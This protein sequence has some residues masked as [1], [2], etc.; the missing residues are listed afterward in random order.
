[1]RASGG[2][3]N[4]AWGTSGGDHEDHDVIILRRLKCDLPMGRAQV[5]SLRPLPLRDFV[6]AREAPEVA[7]A[8]DNQ[9]RWFPRGSV[10]LLFLESGTQTMRH[11]AE[12][13]VATWSNLNTSGSNVMLAPGTDL[14]VAEGASAEVAVAALLEAS[15]VEWE[16]TAND[17]NGRE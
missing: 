15:R 7:L 9:G 10:H 11:W 16:R 4:P 13:P 2:E 3:Y 8:M 14:T 12:G 6:A 5:I 17:A 1:M